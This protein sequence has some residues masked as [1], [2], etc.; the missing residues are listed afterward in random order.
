VFSASLSW[1]SKHSFSVQGGEAADG[2]QQNGMTAGRFPDVGFVQPPT[3]R[4]V[5]PASYSLPCR[6]DPRSRRTMPMLC[7]VQHRDGTEHQDI[8]AAVALPQTVRSVSKAER[9]APRVSTAGSTA[10][11]ISSST[12]T[13]T[14]ASALRN[15]RRTER[16][17]EHLPPL[18]RRPFEPC[19]CP[20]RQP[21]LMSHAR[22]WV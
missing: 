1:C 4:R 20:G 11:A 14:S 5:G 16:R 9:G 12:G 15:G 17:T 7:P 10:G 18:R 19:V 13:S 22:A 21:C 8:A 3:R 2:P 6:I